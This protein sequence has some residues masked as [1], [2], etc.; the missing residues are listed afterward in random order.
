MSSNTI[1]RDVI[2]S[3]KEAIAFIK[4]LLGLDKKIPVGRTLFNLCFGKTDGIE[5]V[6]VYKQSREKIVLVFTNLNLKQRKEEFLKMW[7]VDEFEAFKIYQKA[8]SDVREA[9]EN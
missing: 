9:F 5:K 4:D 1:E 8:L 6:L 7:Q 2:V 3:E